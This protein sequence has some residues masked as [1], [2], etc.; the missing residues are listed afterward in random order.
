MQQLKLIEIEQVC[1]KRVADLHGSWIFW[2]MGNLLY[3]PFYNF[4]IIPVS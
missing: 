2:V 4:S 3:C 1:E